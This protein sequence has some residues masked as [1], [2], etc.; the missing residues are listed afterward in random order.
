M[1]YAAKAKHICFDSNISSSSSSGSSSS[2]TF[3]SCV[4]IS[5]ELAAN[6]LEETSIALNM[7]GNWNFG[8]LL[9]SDSM[10]LYHILASARVLKTTNV[11]ILTISKTSVNQLPCSR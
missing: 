5:D 10:L 4:T 7:L 8:W 6:E 11:Q 9:M 1:K 2:S 3:L